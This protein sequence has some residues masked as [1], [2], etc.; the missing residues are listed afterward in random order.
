MPPGSL[1]RDVACTGEPLPRRGAAPTLPRMMV[2][3]ALSLPWRL[4][5][6]RRCPLILVAGFW[7][8]VQGITPGCGSSNSTDAPALKTLEGPW[9]GEIAL[10]PQP[11]VVGDNRLELTLRDAQGDPLE[12][13]TVEVSPWMP[14]HGHGSKD[15]AAEE[16]E[17]GHYGT[18][19]LHF[20]MPGVWELRIHVVSG[21][22]EGRLVATLEVP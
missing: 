6:T 18:D 3:E 13:A 11:S 14:A 12:G 4:A 8:M 7:L 19:E 15:V 22:T 17:A 10:H 1:R 16:S 2:Q 21:E 20:N 9:G 5:F